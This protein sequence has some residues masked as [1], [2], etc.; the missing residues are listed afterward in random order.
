VTA[1]E[2]QCTLLRLSNPVFS[3]SFWEPQGSSLPA[4]ID[5]DSPPS[6]INALLY[7]MRQNRRHEQDVEQYRLQVHD[8]SGIVFRTIYATAQELERHNA[9]YPVSASG[10]PE[11][12]PDGFLPASLE[13]VSDE[14]LIAELRRRLTG[15]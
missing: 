5:F 10:H 14:Q 3:D 8:D 4:R 13:G 12:G 7:A 6:Q 15:R 2:Y 11:S 9:G 1:R